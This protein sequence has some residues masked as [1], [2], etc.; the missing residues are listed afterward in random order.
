MRWPVDILLYCSVIVH[1]IPLG[2]LGV[3]DSDDAREKPSSYAVDYGIALGTARCSQPR[4]PSAAIPN[5]NENAGSTVRLCFA[6]SSRYF[7]SAAGDWRRAVGSGGVTQ[8][9]VV[10]TC[11]RSLSTDHLIS[12]IDV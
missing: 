10:N 9:N 1:A 3:L 12:D 7:V 6:A 11:A 8:D 2:I 4:K 5:L